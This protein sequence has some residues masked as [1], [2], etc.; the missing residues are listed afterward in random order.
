MV[1]IN[2]SSP[3]RLGSRYLNVTA[4]RANII[5]VVFSNSTPLAIPAQPNTTYPLSLGDGWNMQPSNVMFTT[6]EFDPWRA[7]SLMSLDQDLGAPNRTLI[8][9][10]PKCGEA[11]P[12][13]NVFGMVYDGAVHAEDMGFHPGWPAGSQ[14]QS[15]PPVMQGVTLFVKAYQAWAPCFNQTRRDETAGVGAVRSS[16]ALV[17]GGL[18][19]SLLL[20]VL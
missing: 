4:T 15:N 19:I 5:S 18:G 8:Q 7:F 9:D 10:V 6:G 11:P 16:G 2:A 17:A 3:L 14:D 20:Y 13:T 12:G 1:G